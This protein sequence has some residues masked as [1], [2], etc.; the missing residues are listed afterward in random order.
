VRIVVYPADVR[1]SGVSAELAIT[2]SLQELRAALE[3]EEPAALVIDLESGGHGALDVLRER[4][5]RGS[6]VPVLA[7]APLGDAEA[8]ERARA[9]GCCTLLARESAT[10][11]VV[12]AA[13]NELLELAPSAELI[14][15]AEPTTSGKA[16]ASR[17]PAML[18]KTDPHGGF[19]HFTRR[20]LAYLGKSES[21]ARG[22]GWFECIHPEDRGAWAAA[23]AAR[24]EEPGELATDLRLR[25]AAGVYRW[26]RFAA[27]PGFDAKSEFTGFVGSVFEIDDLVEMRERAR[28]DIARLEVVS[29]E[30]EELA[31]AGAHDLQEPLRSLEH[32]LH[33][34]LAGEAANLP[35]ALR[36]VAHMRELLRDLVDYAGSSA[37]HVAVESTDL[38]QALEWALENLRPA[39]TESAAEI[40]IETLTRVVADP[41]QIARV[42][43]NLVAN[44]LHFRGEERPIISVG[45]E[46]RERDVLICVRDNGIGI[47]AVHHET[48]FR[49]F[50]RLH[51]GE[52]PG[53]GMGLAICRRILERQGGR[54]WVESQPRRGATFYFT[55]PRG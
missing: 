27:L 42:F 10:S 41:I 48:I 14:S 12:S 16:D 37:L 1:I 51:G 33:G 2:R 46:P 21:E 8:A 19:S 36:Q 7:L 22:R 3:A 24:L 28:T 9:L 13:L 49:V 39:I 20:L 47:P 38:A 34:L 54:I 23:F 52:R 11:A 31:F 18:F 6:T 4:R 29:S 32:A 15:S 53:N 43:Q 40:K 35:L 17:A 30:L 45:A 26:V 50:E 25:T 44:A 5:A 55:L